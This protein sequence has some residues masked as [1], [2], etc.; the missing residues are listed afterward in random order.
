MA[1]NTSKYEIITDRRTNKT[2]FNKTVKSNNFN[3]QTVAFQKYLAESFNGGLKIVEPSIVTALNNTESCI[4][5]PCIDSMPWTVDDSTIFQLGKSMAELH[6]YCYR[7]SHCW[8]FLEKKI[9]KTE[10]SGW[11]S[12]E[13]SHD[14]TIAVD[15]R[16]LVYKSLAPYNNKQV[17][18]PLHRD[19][20]LHNIL[21]DGNSFYL[22]DFDFAAIDNIGIE[23]VSFI[24]DF[25]YKHK[26]IKLVEIF[27]DAYKSNSTIPIDWSTMLNDYMVYMCCNTFPFYMRSEIGEDNFKALFDERNLKLHFTYTNKHQI[28]ESLSR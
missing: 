1:G 27:V 16:N 12:I 20:K 26:D 14:K 10:M 19:F 2:V 4:E 11:D 25:Y 3:F 21:H 18:L 15:L 17:C 13:E 22:I 9:N 5:Y 28:Y 7:E 23:I 6:E 24:I 8:E